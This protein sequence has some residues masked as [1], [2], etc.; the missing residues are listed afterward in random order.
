[1]SSQITTD[2]LLLDSGLDAASA[3][4]RLRMRPETGMV[5]VRRQ[6]AEKVT[7]HAL[8][9]NRVERALA[10]QDGLI[11]NLLTLD[12]TNEF[13]EV[14]FADIGGLE[15]MP[16]GVIVDGGVVIGLSENYGAQALDRPRRG[17]GSTII[18]PPQTARPMPPA[19]PNGGSGEPVRGNGGGGS[20]SWRADAALEAPQV[21]EPNSTFTLTVRLDTPESPDSSDVAIELEDDV[22]IIEIDVHLATAFTVM[23]PSNGVGHLSVE[24]ATMVHQ[25]VAFTLRVDDPP[26]TFDPESGT[27]LER[28]QVLFSYRGRPVGQAWREVLV[29]VAGT[30]S[31]RRLLEEASL[32]A[33]AELEIA[34][35]PDDRDLTIEISNAGSP[36]SGD[37]VVRVLSAHL[38]PPIA[39]MQI[40]L[41]ADATSFGTQLIEPIG[42]VVSGMLT[43]ETIL[44]LGD[45]IAAVLPASFWEAI[46]T[47]VAAVSALRPGAVPDVVLLTDERQVPWEL[48]KMPNPADGDRPPL[49]GAQLNIGRWPVKPPLTG[50]TELEV[51]RLGVIV[52]NY[53]LGARVE[54]LPKAVEEAKLLKQTYE[55]V[56]ATA[57]EFGLNQALEGSM[58][59]P[60][61]LIDALH[62]AGHGEQQADAQYS[63]LMLDDGRKVP[64]LI[65]R[66][67]Q[68]AKDRDSFLFLNACQVGVGAER[69]GQAA[70][71]TGSAV[72]GG[73][74]GVVAPL[75]S[76]TDV[77]AKQFAVDFYEAQA[78]GQSIG[79]FMR[80]ARSN[81][82]ENDAGS[83]DSTWVAYVFYGHPRLR[84]NGPARK[85][86]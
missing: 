80:Q 34:E 35:M 19:T 13:P 75:W 51:G 17:G 55:A 26:P 60:G 67:A 4:G 76:V 52:G 38:D 1:M 11:G 59:T 6:L 72:H 20:S 32:D 44:G 7:W 66:Q 37:Y 77:T 79:E 85:T 54:P 46:S 65:F 56:T 69:L 8:S 58:G 31:S 21:V 57:T 73:F 71:A 25:A 22:T 45:T 83:A 82:A 43:Y 47:V 70:G 63:Y 28:I 74:R 23:D 50:E 12:A 15:D 39:P 84:L 18:E 10:G 30:A 5:L 36:A 61:K 29:N 16:H 86:Q 68:L 49:L 62:Y 64:E 42:Q 14:P 3:L 27:W 2:V 9:R 78:A 53:A 81:F 33:G 40:R 24:R 48:A 41:G